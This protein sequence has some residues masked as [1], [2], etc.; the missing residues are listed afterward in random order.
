[1][2]YTW[3]LKYNTKEYIYETETDSQTQRRSMTDIENCGCQVE[4]GMGE[5]W[6][7]NLRLAEAN[8]Q[9]QDG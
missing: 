4:G 3:N 9:I 5:G 6:I 2:T 7:G 1:M 8:Y